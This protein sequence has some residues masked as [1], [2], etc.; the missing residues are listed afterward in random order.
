[1]SGTPEPW[2]IVDD[3]DPGI[4][5]SQITDWTSD[6]NIVDGFRQ[7]ATFASAPQAFFSYHF[8]G[9][10]V[11]LFSP[12]SALNISHETPHPSWECF[13][14]NKSVHTNNSYTNFPIQSLCEVD[15][16]DAKGHVITLQVGTSTGSGSEVSLSFDYLKYLPFV[17]AAILPNATTSISFNNPQAQ[18]G[19]DWNT[20]GSTT[21]CFTTGSDS[22]NS[23]V[24]LI[25]FMG[26]SVEWYGLSTS[27]ITQALAKT[28]FALTLAQNSFK[29]AIDLGSNNSFEAPMEFGEPSV[30]SSYDSML[31]RTPQLS[32]GMHNLTIFFEGS[33]NLTPLTLDF[34]AFS[35]SP[36]SF[37]SSSSGNNSSVTSRPLL[38]PSSSTLVQSSISSGAASTS[39][40]SLNTGSSTTSP[41]T[42]AHKNTALNHGILGG[43]L[44]GIAVVICILVVVLLILRRRTKRR[45][46]SDLLT[47]VPKHTPSRKIYGTLARPFLNRGNFMP[48]PREKFNQ[49][50]ENNPSFGPIH[51]PDSTIT[52]SPLVAM[53]E[54]QKY[55]DR[56]NLTDPSRISQREGDLGA[57]A[58][59]L[60]SPRRLLT[61]DPRTIQPQPSVPN[62]LLI[63]EAIPGGRP[64]THTLSL[65]G[66]S[67]N[68]VESPDR[69]VRHED[70]GVR[71]HPNGEERVVELP[72]TYTPF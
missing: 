46:G 6:T 42:H 62:P 69:V 26:T 43:A 72:P 19:S 57:S 63:H 59:I 15:N 36:T 25:N 49:E 40:T 51:N 34:L 5:Y 64:V 31:F 37:S 18:L 22:E 67:R 53:N 66:M 48:R 55:A 61:S 30:V 50:T 33:A 35:G 11:A 65:G 1:M 38:N 54:P 17:P 58:P 44:G 20:L 7:T 52:G 32:A 10:K 9:S 28:P 2:V 68:N 23:D 13:L 41:Q 16:L 47:I 27:A 45:N 29:Y 70:S 8:N 60:P 21:A 4:L 3:T 14:D 24:L 39:A 56:L 71:L 12:F